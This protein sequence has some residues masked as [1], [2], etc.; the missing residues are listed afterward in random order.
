M[1][2]PEVHLVGGT[3][4]EALRLAPVASAVRA[5]GRLTP[6]LLAGG[7]DPAAV[8]RTFAAFGRPADVTLPAT[9]DPADTL[10]RLDQLWAV[11][12]PAAVLV[13]GDNLA[14]ALAAYWR[15]IPVMH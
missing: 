6:V 14:A 9:E 1:S 10:R 15:R 3:C 5:Q 7:A 8:A 12:T 2:L 11:R 13:R 4:A